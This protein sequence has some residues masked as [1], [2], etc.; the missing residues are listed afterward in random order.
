[1]LALVAAGLAAAGLLSF[2]LSS[3]GTGGGVS[4]PI[5]W[6]PTKPDIGAA[7]PPL[8]PACT[9]SQLRTTFEIQGL[10]MY[11]AVGGISVVNTSST[12]CSLVGLPRFSMAGT[13]APLHV[14]RMNGPLSVP[15]DPLAPPVGSLR[16]LRPGRHVSVVLLVSV[17][18]Q[19][20][21]GSPCGRSPNASGALMFDAP[22]GGR[23][24]LL[25]TNS[26]S[27]EPFSRD[28]ILQ[29]TRF[30]PVVPTG[31]PSSAL[32]LRAR[33]VGAAL[34]HIKA[35]TQRSFI[36]RAGSWMSFAVVLTNVGHGRFVFGSKCPAYTEDWGGLA[37][38]ARAYVL[39]CHP[40][41]SIASGQSVRFAMR[42]RVPHT[43]LPF[44]WFGWTL[45]PH[46]YK[47]PTAGGMVKIRPLTR[48][49]K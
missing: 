7:H 30:T 16:A 18:C 23:I 19:A 46:T 34:I 15:F 37:R 35:T 21:V 33:V 31:P 10:N 2:E 6:L 44:G 24:R 43:S 4:A 36:A 9:G 48:L 22:G 20:D 47:A 40:V 29:A 39:N 42:I 14:A 38:S 41:G 49:P 1:M 3:S 25:N 17:P 28:E 13:K 27:A 5:P 12:P 32:P 26:K 45:S 11:Q 8:A